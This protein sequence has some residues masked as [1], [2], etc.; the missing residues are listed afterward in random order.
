MR[1][2]PPLPAD[3][4]RT[5]VRT[6]ADRHG[7]LGFRAARSH[8]LVTIDDCLVAHPGIAELIA[9]ARVEG[10]ADVTLRV[11]ARTGERLAVWDGPGSPDG[12]PDD[13]ALGEGAILHERVGDR[14][15]RVSARSFFQSSPEAAEALVAEVLSA[16]G[17]SAT[18]GPVVD[19]YGGVGLFAGAMPPDTP[20]TLLE[21]SAS[22]IADA[23]ANLADRPVRVVEGA[24]ED[25]SPVAASLV[26]ADPARRGLGE[27]A[28]GVLAATGCATFVL[29]SCD[30]A[31]GAR[32]VRTLMAKGFR[33]RRSVVLDPFPHTAHVEVVSLLTR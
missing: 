29:V 9:V 22:S 14:T 17:A 20:V 28:A 26:I 31:A 19:A 33:H 8:D 1:S 16:A 11:G 15:L 21:L 5:T 2:G 25:W 24:V 10:A 12:F 18:D 7:R 23:R 13:V 4:F 27:D 32:D 3:R 6:V 30:A